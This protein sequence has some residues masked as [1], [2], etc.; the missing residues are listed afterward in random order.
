MKKIQKPCYHRQS[1]PIQ[2]PTKY[3]E[4][5]FFSHM[6]SDE[7]SEIKTVRNSD[8]ANIWRR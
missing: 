6:E 1:Y 4:G 3:D 2:N 8:V 5:S 7:A